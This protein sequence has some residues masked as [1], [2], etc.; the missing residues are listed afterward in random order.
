[1]CDHMCTPVFG[2]TAGA[3][4]EYMTCQHCMC[5]AVERQVSRVTQAVQTSRPTIDI[6]PLKGTLVGVVEPKLGFQDG[7]SY[8]THLPET[9][10]G[11]Q[12]WDS[13]QCLRN[14]IM[15][16]SRIFV[17]TL[18]RIFVCGILAKNVVYAI[19]SRQLPFSSIGSN[20]CTFSRTQGHHHAHMGFPVSTGVGTCITPLGR[21]ASTLFSFLLLT[22][23]YCAFGLDLIAE[24]NG[25]V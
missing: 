11:F 17:N 23:P 9:R 1:M 3:L 19:Q 7:G 8:S 24:K 22:Y 16:L 14:K 12:F 21:F 2:H 5:I 13:E 25:A 20:I 6:N 10:G 4:S 18:S 15:T